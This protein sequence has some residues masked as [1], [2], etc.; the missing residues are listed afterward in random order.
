[1]NLIIRRKLRFIFLIVGTLVFLTY[2]QISAALPSYKRLWEKKYAYAT[3]CTLC[4][5]KGG[6]SQLNGYGEDFQ[7]FGMTPASFLTIEKR[8]S[9]KDGISNINEITGKSN[10]GD[11]AYLKTLRTGLAELKNPHSR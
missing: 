7:R 11:S 3:S 5:S 10:P 2:S 6:G 9:D 1:M 8:D 4:H